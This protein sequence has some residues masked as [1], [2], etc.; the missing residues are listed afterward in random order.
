MGSI[1][2]LLEPVP[3]AA[4]QGRTSHRVVQALGLDFIQ[5]EICAEAEPKQRLN[6]LSEGITANFR[7]VR[8]ENP[9]RVPRWQIPVS[10]TV[11]LLH[12]FI[13]PFIAESVSEVRE[14]GGHLH[15]TRCGV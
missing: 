10:V 1:I 4:P 5:L 6:P 11:N 12:V 7:R 2:Q 13:C 8:R 15:L 3:R 14:G 9:R